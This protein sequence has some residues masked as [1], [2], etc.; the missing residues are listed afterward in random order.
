MHLFA[1]RVLTDGAPR[2]RNYPTSFEYILYIVLQRV[3]IFVT[4]LGH[5]IVHPVKV[6]LSPKV[7]RLGES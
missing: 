7:S 1:K 4:Y 6:L 3:R 2:L 5:R